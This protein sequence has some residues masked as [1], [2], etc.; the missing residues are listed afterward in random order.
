MDRRDMPGKLFGP[1]VAA[2]QPEAKPCPRQ[3]SRQIQGRV[4]AILPPKDAWPRQYHRD[5]SV[6]ARTRMRS[7]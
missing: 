1:T 7:R 5:D 3:D 6:P 4:V 2:N